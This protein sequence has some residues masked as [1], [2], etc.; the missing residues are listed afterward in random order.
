MINTS[1]PDDCQPFP[2]PVLRFQISAPSRTLS[3]LLSFS[4]SLASI[5]PRKPSCRL[6]AAFLPTR[7]YVG[8]GP[9]IKRKL[10]EILLGDKI[11]AAAWVGQ[12]CP[13]H[14]A[15]VVGVLSSLIVA[16]V[17]TETTA[18][19]STS[20]LLLKL[21][22][23]DTKDDVS[24]T[25]FMRFDA[26]FEQALASFVGWRKGVCGS[27]CPDPEFLLLNVH[28]GEKAY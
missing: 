26:A 15:S 18:A 25:R 11:M 16:R 2:A 3:A 17:T 14:G 10:T 1:P 5:S 22:R 21:G 24:C 27:L 12:L 8:K 9:P 28:G 20:S 23:A 6:S 13:S 4:V 7:C 19:S